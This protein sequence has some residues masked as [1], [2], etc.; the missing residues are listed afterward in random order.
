MGNLGKIK[1]LATIGGAMP[2]M[3]QGYYCTVNDLPSGD[4]YEHYSRNIEG[5]AQDV[6]FIEDPVGGGYMVMPA[7][8]SLL[9]S[10]YVTGATNST[11]KSNPRIV[12]DV[13]PYDGNGDL[14]S[15][16]GSEFL[17]NMITNK[18]QTI[19]VPN[20]AVGSTKYQDSYNGPRWDIPQGVNQIAPADTSATATV[21][22]TTI[23]TSTSPTA[24]ESLGLSY[25]AQESICDDI[26][27]SIETKSLATNEVGTP[28]F[29]NVALNRPLAVKQSTFFALRIGDITSTSTTTASASAAK[30]IIDL[31]FVDGSP[32]V[33]YDWGMPI[34]IPATTTAET[35]TQ[36]SKINLPQTLSWDHKIHHIEIVPTAGKLCITI[37]GQVFVYTRIDLGT[38]STKNTTT[39]TQ[40]S[41][42]IT[43]GAIPFCPSLKQI[44]AIGTNSQVVL[45]LGE[46]YFPE[47]AVFH[48]NLNGGFDPTATVNSSTLPM[49]GAKDGLANSTDTTSTMVHLPNEQSGKPT[50]GAFAKKCDGVTLDATDTWGTWAAGKMHGELKF[51]LVDNT[52]GGAAGSAIGKHY[53]ISFFS[54]KAK[55]G[56]CD[57]AAGGTT[58]VAQKKYI[59]APIWFRAR[60]VASKKLLTTPSVYQITDVSDSVMEITESIQSPDR[61]HVTHS[62]DITLYNEDGIYD[63][64]SENS[65][66]IRVGLKWGKMDGQNDP[67]TTNFFTG[68]TLNASRTLVA[69]KETIT[70]HCEDYMFL[71]D[72][73]LI[74]NSPYYDGM[75]GFNVVQDVSSRACVEAIDDTGVEAGERFFMPSGYS[76]LQPAK[77]YDS[78]ESLRSC[79]VDVCS[80]GAKVAY[81]DGD[82][83]L[84]YDHIQGGVSF[85]S[86]PSEIDAA[87][88]YV[89][90]PS[91]AEDKKLILDE[92]RTETKLNSTVNRI[93]VKSICR[94][95]RAIIMVSKTADN[96]AN[97][98]SYR[99]TMFASVPS[100]GSFDATV[101]YI[102]NLKPIVFKAIRGITIKTADDSSLAFPM[103]FM[104]VDGEKYRI[105]SI[106]RSIRADDNS[107]TTSLTGEW[108]GDY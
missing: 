94:T 92:K 40:N 13:L 106:N 32:A 102:E 14:K 80:M 39:A 47:K 1:V 95:T 24:A 60:G 3:T 15:C 61:Y 31:V 45:S 99:K 17:E 89:S 93:V 84:H 52:S 46:I 57:T 75:D 7:K 86:Q 54:E 82:G 11:S 104:D 29:V 66:P 25:I 23:G 27:W 48:T 35:T 22:S 10:N 62:L 97:R 36:P 79:I 43:R 41:T 55:F 96:T 78:K 8:R 71:L 19:V 38:V 56:E 26:W 67:I 63:A 37:D 6:D 21:S 42:S 20:S 100:L 108:M 12:W 30:D 4:A 87:V 107:I 98:L 28:F 74:I 53:T 34:A 64:V 65:V 50:L 85:S 70:I 72:S 59:L 58:D 33:L 16:V 83:K 103:S 2:S 77:R 81:F 90:Y 69:G 105:M 9:I 18:K 68:V 5:P 88:S 101:A 73:T 49:K 51:D 91:D 76:F 44:R